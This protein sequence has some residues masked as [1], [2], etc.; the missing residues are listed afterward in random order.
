MHPQSIENPIPK[1]RKDPGWRSQFSHPR[2]LGG[3]LVGH[4]MSIKNKERSLWVLSL[5]ELSAADRVLELGFGSGSDIQRV[6][7]RLPNGLVAGID[8]S[9]SMFRMATLKNTAAI[10]AGHVKLCQGSASH[11][12]YESSSFDVAFS[13]NVAQ[14]WDPPAEV[15][16]EIRRVLKPGG[17]V[18]L[19]VQPRSKG[20]D[21]ATA[22]ATGE[23][24]VEALEEAGFTQVRLERKPLRPVPVVCALAIK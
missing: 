3:W 12:P 22:R 20:A 14:F 8:H 7:A 15:A 23:K 10:R 24:L 4:L 21:E 1:R 9:D 17:R 11:L 5:L 6:A 13:I 18:A 2:G 16:R 19:A